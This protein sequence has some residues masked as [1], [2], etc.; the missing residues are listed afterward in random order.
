MNAGIYSITAREI[1]DSRG[2]PTIESTVLLNSGYRGIAAVPAGASRG[3]YEAVELRDDDPKRYNGQ[4]VLKAIHNVVNVITPKLKAQDALNQKSIDETLLHL[5]GTPNK[6]KL[7][8]NAIL[9]V[10][11]ATAIAAAN[12]Q[13]IPLYKYINALLGMYL[14]VPIQRIPTPTFNLING[15]AHGAGNINFQEFHVIP[16]SNKS[17]H[18]ALQMGTEIYMSVKKILEYRN[19]IHSIGDE[20]GFAPNLFLNTDALEILSEAV[21]ATPYRL[22]VDIFLGLDVAAT[23]FK[24]DRGY[25]IKDRPSAFSTKDFIGFLKEIH[26]KY[27]LLYLEDPLEEDDW[28]GWRELTAL[29]GNEVNIV[30]DDLLVTNSQRLKKAIDQQAANAILLKP[31]QIGSLSEFLQV[32]VMAKK[33]GFKTIVSHRSGETNDSYISDIAVGIQSEYAKF[34]APAR[35]E[36]VVKYNRLLAIEQELFPQ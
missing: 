31:N 1:L 22:T 35:G 33:N 6:S 19:A 14:E 21:K 29:M 10:S 26:S 5:D 8:A 9:S 2:N 7:G 18:E 24:K 28:E 36:R 27:H 16:A 15:G 4:G 23:Q 13:R 12:H 11:M 30:G 3:K 32:V 34:G 25:E 17:Y 20:G